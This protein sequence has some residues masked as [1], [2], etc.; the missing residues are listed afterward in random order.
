MSKETDFLDLIPDDFEFPEIEV[1]AED[2]DPDFIQHYSQIL[3][4][5]KIK[6]VRFEDPG[7]KDKIKFTPW[8]EI[9]ELKDVAEA[10]FE[11]DYSL[12]YVGYK[13]IQK[14]GVIPYH[15][16][17]RN[18]VISGKFYDKF[19]QKMEV[20]LDSCHFGHTYNNKKMELH[21]FY[22]SM[23][24]MVLFFDGHSSYLL[25][26]PEYLNDKE[27][28]LYTLL[29]IIKNYK[30][31]LVVKNKIYVVYRSSNGFQ[32][33]PFDVKKRNINISDNYNEDFPEISE[34]IIGKLNDKKKTG[35]V[36]LHGEPGTGKT[37]YIRYLASKLKRN[38][39]FISP[40]MVH[41]ITSP[42][43][44]PFLLDNS[45]SILII[46]DAEPALQ[47]RLG[48]GRSGAVSNILNM[49]DGLLSDCLN[50]SI[51]ATFNTTTK[52][53]DEALLRQG[54][55]LK[56]YKF[57]KLSKEKAQ[58]LAKKLGKNIEVKEPMSLAQ[59]YFYGDDTKGEDFHA[60]K[61]GFGYKS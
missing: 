6:K 7:V 29:G 46:E 34:E 2:E 38:I 13:Y 31:P 1:Y 33:K 50:I 48:D 25:Y 19:F 37:T 20:P 9:F 36:I 17:I 35:L 52:D 45:D 60:R 4:F 49:T 58:E 16:T 3:D 18:E 41:H 51:V 32:K 14:Y 8:K 12:S 26:P 10:D 28:P 11:A 42:E 56:S 57:D 39:I 40:D 53:I 59:I 5:T 21:F 15:L 43:F 55:L 23:E 30:L 54:R 61:A 47:K 44:I 22:F 24:K 27:S